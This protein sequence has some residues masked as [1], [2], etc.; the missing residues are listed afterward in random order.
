M[1]INAITDLDT[2]SNRNQKLLNLAYRSNLIQKPLLE[3]QYNLLFYFDFISI[4]MQIAL[5]QILIENN[6]KAVRI[7][8][9]CLKHVL[10][11]SH[12]FF[13]NLTVNNSLLIYSNLNYTFNYSV[14]LK[15]NTVKGIHFMGA[16]VN[17]QYLRP[18]E[19][20]KISMISKKTPEKHICKLLKFTKN[21]ITK[22]IFLKKTRL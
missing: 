22:T 3:K 19:L 18:S 5:K 11:D 21:C 2:I 15:L 16:W 13:Q 8:K 1:C 12:N 6:L 10:A 20:K 14:I 4:E 9:N 17:K 7:K